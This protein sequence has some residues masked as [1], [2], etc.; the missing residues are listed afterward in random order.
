MRKLMSSKMMKGSFVREHVLGMINHFN[1]LD[2]LGGGIE[3]STKVDMVLHTLPKSYEN[4]R[5]NAVM[6]KKKFTLNKLL[7]ELV[8]AERVMGKSPQALATATRPSFPPKGR[9]KKGPH[10]KRGQAKGVP[11]DK[12]A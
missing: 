12:G 4:F 11:A 6:G 3:D 8:A 1:E 7:N 2:V 9:K 10:G 5:L